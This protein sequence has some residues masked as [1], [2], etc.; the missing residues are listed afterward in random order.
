MFISR[1]DISDVI[2]YQLKLQLKEVISR[3]KIIQEI[4]F[5]LQTVIL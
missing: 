1:H 3:Y 4:S 5:K 2:I